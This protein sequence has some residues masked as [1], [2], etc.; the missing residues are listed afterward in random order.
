M[1]TALCPGSF[2]PVTLR[3]PRHHRAH[4]P[5]LRRRHRRGHPQPAEDAVAVQ[6]R[7]APGDAA[8]GHRAP[9]QHPDRVLQGA[10]RRL[11]Q[12][13]R[14]RRDR[15]GPARGLRLRLRAADGADEPAAHRA[16]TRSSSRPARSTR[17]C[18]RAWCA[19]SPRFGGDVSSMVPEHVAKRLAG[20]VPTEA[21]R[22]EEGGEHARGRARQ[23]TRHRRPAA[24]AAGA[25]RER[26]RDAAVGVGDGEPGGVR[27]AA[28]RTRSTA[29]PRSCARRAGC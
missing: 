7:G 12:G 16:S 22:D 3:P 18:R 13:P 25:A 4:G 1:A 19:R 2:D 10:A 27:R 9:R 11:R 26:A 5:S 23:G 14:R 15:E 29:C 8:R 17:S 21:T 24:A 20:A 6:P 28:R